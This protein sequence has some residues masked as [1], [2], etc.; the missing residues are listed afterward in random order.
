MTLKASIGERVLC[1]YRDILYMA[2]NFKTYMPICT[3][4]SSQLQV[5]YMKYGLIEI[6]LGG[7]EP[8]R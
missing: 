7:G 3:M 5:F 8:Y 1:V 4:K 6:E 2:Q